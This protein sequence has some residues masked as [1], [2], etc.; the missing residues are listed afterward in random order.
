MEWGGQ[1]ISPSLVIVTSSS[2]NEGDF[3]HASAAFSAA[4][5]SS[6]PAA[7]V[8]G[9][10][11]MFCHRSR[12]FPVVSGIQMDWYPLAWASVERLSTGVSCGLWPRACMSSCVIVVARVANG[13]I[14]SKFVRRTRVSYYPG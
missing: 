3:L 2:K 14:F 12:H 7:P 10:M 8:E 1:Q 6:L 5:T 11:H 9:M 13:A 4:I